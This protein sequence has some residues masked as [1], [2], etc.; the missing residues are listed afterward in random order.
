MDSGK[1]SP[2]GGAPPACFQCGECSG[3]CPLFA[4]APKTYNPRRIVAGLQRDQAPEG[5]VAWLCLACHECTERCPAGVSVAD[6]NSALRRAAFADGYAPKA[7]R[8]IATALPRYGYVYEI[9]EFQ[10]DMRADDGLPP[11]PEPATKEVEA[12]MRRTG[13]IAKLGGDEK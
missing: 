8:A 6:I 7:I 13:I 5:S 1:D 3:S 2:L 11:A 12:I 4:T 9:G 10:N